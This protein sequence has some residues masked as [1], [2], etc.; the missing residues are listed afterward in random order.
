MKRSWNS[1]KTIIETISWGTFPRLF[2]YK[3]WLLYLPKGACTWDEYLWT[4]CQFSRDPGLQCHLHF[5]NWWEIIWFSMNSM[6]G[7]LSLQGWH[8]RHISL[9]VISLG[10]PAN[11]DVVSQSRSLIRWHWSHDY[12]AK[13]SQSEEGWLKESVA[14]KRG[15]WTYCFR[16]LMN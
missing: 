5:I 4:S 3:M 11:T 16:Q 10:R 13:D 6:Q 8:M 12:P 9:S 1:L 2:V 15:N 7:N 14:L